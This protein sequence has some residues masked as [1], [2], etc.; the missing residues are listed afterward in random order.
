MN[1]LCKK[2]LQTKDISLFPVDRRRPTGRHPYCKECRSSGDRAYYLSH[3]SHIISKVQEAYWREPERHRSYVKE[4]RMRNKHRLR[5][6]LLR[7]LYGLSLPEYQVMFMAQ[8]GLCAICKAPETVIVN[9]KVISLAVD[10]DHK[11]G[12]V[13]E[14]LC[15][16]C[17]AHLGKLGDNLQYIRKLYLYLLKHSFKVG[18]KCT[19]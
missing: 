15:R 13:R 5:D 2:C 1:T 12:L 7:R 10:H 8:N 19:S 9:G 16:R 14:L 11:T 3:R 4:Y 17:N 18:K 6:G